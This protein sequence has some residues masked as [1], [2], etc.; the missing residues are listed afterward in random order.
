VPGGQLLDATVAEDLYGIEVKRREHYFSFDIGLYKSWAARAEIWLDEEPIDPKDDSDLHT[1]A[2]DLHQVGV[3]KE[4]CEN[5]G[6]EDS[7][8]TIGERGTSSDPSLQQLSGAHRVEQDPTDSC[9]NGGS[10]DVDVNA[11]ANSSGQAS[12]IDSG[13]QNRSYIHAIHHKESQSGGKG[14][15]YSKQARM[16]PLPGLLDHREFV[17]VQVISGR[18]DVCGERP[19]EY[20]CKEKQVGICEECYTSLS[21]EWNQKNGIF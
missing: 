5:E 14:G 15:K 8:K 2:S 21:R 20:R 16:N 4:G 18:C 1:F 13:N 9:S 6:R 19:A 12:F 17:K 10:S 11:R 3:K 7:N